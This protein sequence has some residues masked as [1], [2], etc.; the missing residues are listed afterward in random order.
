MG[1][2]GKRAD[3]H[4]ASLLEFVDCLINL[5]DLKMAN[6][7]VAICSLPA[8]GLYQDMARHLEI[9]AYPTCI[10]QILLPS[11]FSAEK[12]PF[13]VAVQHSR[14]MTLSNA[15]LAM[16]GIRILN[17]EK[18]VKNHEGACMDAR[19][20]VHGQ[21]PIIG[22]GGASE[23]DA[24]AL[25]IASRIGCLIY[26]K[27]N[28]KT[29][30][31]LIEWF[32]ELIWRRM[33]GFNT[34]R[35][36]VEVIQWMERHE[37]RFV[38]LATSFNDPKQDKKRGADFLMKL[39]RNGQKGTVTF[40]L[41]VKA[42]WREIPWHALHHPRVS[43]LVRSKNPSSLTDE[44][45]GRLDFQERSLLREGGKALL[46][47]DLFLAMRHFLEAKKPYIPYAHP[48]LTWLTEL[49][50][51][52]DAP[53]RAFRVEA[54]WKTP[55][56]DTHAVCRAKVVLTGAERQIAELYLVALPERFMDFCE[57]R[58]DATAFELK[59]EMTD[60]DKKRFIAAVSKVLRQSAEIRLARAQHL[61][62]R[63]STFLSRVSRFNNRCLPAGDITE[64]AQLVFGS[65]YRCMEEAQVLATMRSGGQWLFSAEE[66]SSFNSK[67][68]KANGVASRALEI[69]K[70]TGKLD[71]LSA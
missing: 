62:A 18:L 60:E 23:V 48:I 50:K 58:P 26:T 59:V 56:D 61:P 9:R 6:L 7:P 39:W 40:R 10:L 44:A 15:P 12:V 1:N 29:Q 19:S 63:K 55:G 22:E 28:D 43:A 57:K 54:D 69:L 3:D 4:A 53:L 33:S 37:K 5:T 66:L 49:I 27:L 35:D 67:N 16:Q 30:P 32:K 17:A 71:L 41:Q 45:Y 20:M 52:N 47:E 36:T 51:S 42:H 46:Q 21:Y 14:R 25:N 24:V 64:V 68:S 2:G 65:L 38:N 34:E 70:S 31:M 11:A 8:E 13:Y